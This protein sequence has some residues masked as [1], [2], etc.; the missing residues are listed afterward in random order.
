VIERMEY[1]PDMDVAELKVE[2]E[3]RGIRRAKIGGFDLDGVLRGKYVSLEK[4][5]SAIEKGFGFCDVIFG[6]DVCDALYDNAT[7]TGWHSPSCR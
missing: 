2:F 4:L 6:W 7:L 1:H 5:W 3:R